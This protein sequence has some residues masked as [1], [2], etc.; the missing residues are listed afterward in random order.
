MKLL[1]AL[2][3]AAA[4]TAAAYWLSGPGGSSKG[5]MS[6]DG[7][8]RHPSHGIDSH[9]LPNIIEAALPPH[10]RSTGEA[11]TV[12]TCRAIPGRRMLSLVA[13]PSFAAERPLP[14]PHPLPKPSASTL[15]PTGV[16]RSVPSHAALQCS[17]DGIEVAGWGIAFLFSPTGTLRL[18]PAPTS[19]PH[20]THPTGSKR[21][22][23]FKS[24]LRSFP[25]APCSDTVAR[26]L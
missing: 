1:G 12:N 18:Y 11:K 26:P 8:H 17:A 7:Q 4:A 3:A 13:L 16:G 25:Y 15:S 6:A 5:G 21:V 2:A 14:N 9:K 10:H 19:R 23:R 24:T 20:P 22:P